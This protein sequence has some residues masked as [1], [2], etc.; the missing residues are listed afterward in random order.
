MIE[1]VAFFAPTS[2]PE[3]GAS[4]AWSPLADA[5]AAISRLKAGSV[6]VISIED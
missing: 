4:I 6:V 1:S 5:A 2:P 3:T